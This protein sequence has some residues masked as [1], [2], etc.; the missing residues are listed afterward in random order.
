MASRYTRDNLLKII[1][2]DKATLGSPIEGDLT[3]RTTIEYQCACGKQHSKIFS[4]LVHGG[5]GA[6]CPNCAI[7]RGVERRL[8][9]LES[10]D[11]KTL[12][13]GSTDFNRELAETSAS[14]VG[15]VLVG[16]YQRNKDGSRGVEI[17]GNKASRDCFLQIKCKCG[18]D[19]FIIFRDAYDG[20]CL[21]KPC[22]KGHKSNALRI[23]RS[24]GDPSNIIA[25][26][27]SKRANRI[28]NDG[29]ECTDCNTIKP[30]SDFSSEFNPIEK[31]KIYKSRCYECSRKLRTL[32]REESLRNGSLE[33]FM[34]SQITDAKQ[35]NSA[36]NRA[37]PDDVRDFNL[38]ASFLMELFEKQD[39]KCALT[40]IPMLTNS[41]RDDRPDNVRCN[42]NKMS[43][44]RIDSKLGYTTDNVQLLT[45]ITNSEKMDMTNEQFI[46][47]TIDRYKFLATLS[48]AKDLIK[49]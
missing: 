7:K 9:T 5:G 19:D 4:N 8:K 1:G 28:E 33:D 36:Y 10:E 31:C 29:Q 43:I 26:S 45:W 24:G 12:N 15:S 47:R 22:R 17:T 11:V 49:S 35:R 42:P 27:L 40:G 44:D 34:K 23:T 32:N 25:E 41:H 21:C 13:T 38:T 39:G 37:H 16:V 6:I 20:L 46:Q 2:D 48:I 30:A 3:S 14:K 18:N